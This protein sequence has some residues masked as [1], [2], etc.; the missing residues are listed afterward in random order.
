MTEAPPLE[1][2]ETLALRWPEGQAPPAKPTLDP[3]YRLRTM[4]DARP[5]RRVQATIGFHVAEDA[6]RSLRTNL[7]EDAMVFATRAE[8]PV[9]V[10][11]AERR[12]D[13]V[14]LGWVAVSPADR[15]RGLGLAVC[16]ALTRQLL[17]SGET[18]VF[19]S[20]QDHRL[21]ALK[22]YLSLGFHPVVRGKGERWR[23]VHEQLGLQPIKA[24]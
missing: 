21:A 10:A 5:F 8:V 6:W 12:G 11:A 14:E 22:I 4:V 15:G 2:A 18:K 3:E 24:L 7:V 17:K 9:G 20:T 16:A 1:R 23:A 13:W 19:L